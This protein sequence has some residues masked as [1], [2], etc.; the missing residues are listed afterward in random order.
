MDKFQLSAHVQNMAQAKNDVDERHVGKLLGKWGFCA[1]G[2]FRQPA[3]HPP[4]RTTK[5]KISGA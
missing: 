4:Q 3:M 1:R 5:V 2:E